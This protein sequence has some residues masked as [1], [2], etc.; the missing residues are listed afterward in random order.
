MAFT[1]AMNPAGGYITEGMQNM[2]NYRKWD[3]PSRAN[4]NYR[5]PVKEAGLGT[6]L[7]AIFKGGQAGWKWYNSPAGK[8]TTETVGEFLK[9][10][11]HSSRRGTGTGKGRKFRGDGRANQMRPP[12]GGVTQKAAEAAARRVISRSRRT[13]KYNTW[14]G[15][16]KIGTGAL[17]AYG[18]Y[19]IG[20]DLLTVGRWGAEELGIN[21]K[22]WQGFT[23]GAL[24]GMPHL[25][26]P[27]ASF[28]FNSG[29]YFERRR[30]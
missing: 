19:E 7:Q 22:N 16:G 29:S 14:K 27:T 11:Y 4:P 21:Y 2:K 23:K 18:A 28:R 15:A 1:S 25:A 13:G 8:K 24:Q 3:T 12:R 10:V 9:S 30:R 26:P 6:I 17:L 5:A 20:R